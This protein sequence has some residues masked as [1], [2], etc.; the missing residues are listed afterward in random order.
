MSRKPECSRVELIVPN[1]QT[2]TRRFA[3]KADERIFSVSGV[4]QVRSSGSRNW[5][6]LSGAQLPNG[7][8][9]M[10]PQPTQSGLGCRRWK[11]QCPDR[12]PTAGSAASD[13]EKGSSKGWNSARSRM[14]CADLLGQARDNTAFPPRP[15][16]QPQTSRCSPPH[17]SSQRLFLCRPR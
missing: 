11:T 1:R 2:L 17:L 5:A 4:K 3:M 9:P 13:I 14:K 12:N 16:K 8:D 15:K 7:P 6:P 10:T